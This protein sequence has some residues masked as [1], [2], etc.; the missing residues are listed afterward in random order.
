[1]AMR[2]WGVKYSGLVR[3]F[4]L[5]R[6]Q[7]SEAALLLDS[8]I[9]PVQPEKIRHIL[10]GKAALVVGSGPSVFSAIPVLKKYR[11]NPR[12]VA[13]S[14]VRT[15]LENGIFPDIVVTDLDG[16]V[17]SLRRAARSGAIMVVHAHGDNI[18]RLQLA[19]EFQSCIGTT[20]TR[21]LGRLCNFG[22]FTDGDRCVFL[23]SAFGAAKIILFGMDF[24]G[25]IG[26][27][28][29]TPASERKR[30]LRK[31]H[32]ARMLLQ[33]MATRSGSELYTT[34]GRIA[35]FKKIRYKDLSVLAAHAGAKK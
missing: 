5:S 28:S 26:R 35:G 13:D 9:D 27:C 21:P 33:W 4:G 16:D 22:G 31:L 1:M 18:G 8:I 10:E 30:K 2:G 11:Y 3:E 24:D 23:A 12:I 15:L 32:R 6:R 20:Q 14:A 19:G 7:D 25:R 29:G 34:S 17:P